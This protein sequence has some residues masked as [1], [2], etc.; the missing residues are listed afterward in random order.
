MADRRR[1]F[2]PLTLHQLAA[3]KLP[4]TPEEMDDDESSKPLKLV[5]QTPPRA[6]NYSMPH[7]GYYSPISPDQDVNLQNLT[8]PTHPFG[9]HPSAW[10]S[11]SSFAPSITRTPESAFRPEITANH[12]TAIKN[13]RAHLN[14][15]RDV[16]IKENNATLLN[17]LKSRN[18]NIEEAAVG[19]D[20][21]MEAIQRTRASRADNEDF[22]RRFNRRG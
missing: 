13:F 1:A 2:L 11:A 10:S 12:D 21:R 22:V 4:N 15:N 19:Y 20:A 17:Y 5:T 14:A 3:L 8:A 18:F 9:Q 6:V 7:P 16:P